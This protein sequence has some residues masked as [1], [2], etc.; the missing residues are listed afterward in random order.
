MS[1]ML[2]VRKATVKDLK[3]ISVIHKERFHDHFLGKFSLETITDFY[4]I[5]LDD[6]FIFLVAEDD[7][8]VVGFVLGGKGAD[9]R[10]VNNTFM[11]Q[12]VWYN[13]LQI[14][15]TPRLWIDVIK[16]IRKMIFKKRCG[17][18]NTTSINET[19][20]LLSIAVSSARGKKGIG[21][22][23]VYEFDK[24]VINY[25]NEYRLCVHPNNTVATAFYERLG[26]RKLY[27][28]ADLACY[29]KNLI[30]E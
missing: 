19:I 21:S 30:P 5:Y 6:S 27:S 22:A 28:R 20:S 26:Y 9:I 14:I 7:T 29:G 16:R 10:R 4:R 24:R 15:I 2:N 17:R 8:S 25:S 1:Q 13:I 3:E 11:K 18:K 12:N 23:L